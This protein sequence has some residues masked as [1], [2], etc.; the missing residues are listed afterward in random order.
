M[1]ALKVCNFIYRLLP[2]RQLSSALYITGEKAQTNFALLT[3]VI[4][5]EE[6]VKDKENLRQNIVA[7]HLPIDLEKLIQRWIFFQF[8]Q[9]RKD[10]LEH[11][12]SELGILITDLMKT[13]EENKED[14]EKLKLHMK[15]V[16][17]DL[18]NIKTF[19]YAAEEETMLNILNLPNT[20]HE[21]T[22]L[23]DEKVVYTFL[24]KSSGS[25]EHHI[26]IGNKKGLFKYLDSLT[27]F[28]KSEAAIFELSLLNY[29][30]HN[31][32]KSG[33]FQLASPNFC[34]SVIA[35]GCGKNPS[36]LFCIRADELVDKVNKL[37]FCGGSSL[38]AFMAFFTKLVINSNLLPIKC[39]SIGKVYQPCP[40]S[41]PPS[42]FNF[43]QQSTVSFF[44]AMSNENDSLKT[45]IEE[46][47]TLYQNLGYHFRLVLLPADRLDKAESS[48]LSIQMFSNYLGK[49]VEVGNIS[50][51]G[52]YLCKRL[53][54]SYTK[55]N[56]RLYPKI[57]SGT[58]L[59]VPK[60][61]GCVLENHS[62]SGNDLLNDTLK[63]YVS[64]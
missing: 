44:I 23:T 41:K 53:L 16:K 59:N 25:S 58:L 45:L 49:Y 6:K 56:E 3:P 40:S 27:C 15:M 33:Y 42:L 5:F 17:E 46:V 10:V 4:D 20:L 31:L 26:K 8:M 28:W 24:E 11:T 62:L 22:P 51:Y 64:K 63:E 7:R 52:S 2:R 55:K 57:I 1:L 37:H 50:L 48:R 61:L 47:K 60:V 29:F 39:F 43:S 38:F 13:S 21:D 35:E 14:I 12:K 9:E 19:Y 30:R 54:F 34:K 18:R 32:D 36:K